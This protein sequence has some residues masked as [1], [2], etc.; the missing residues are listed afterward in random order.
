[1]TRVDVQD[2]GVGLSEQDQEVVFDRLWRADSA[3]ESNNGGL[4]IGLA[5]VR[6]IMDCMGGRAS[7]KSRLGE[8]STFT[9]YFPLSDL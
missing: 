8:G 7:V 5:M 3:R 4:G 6:E 2:S 9:L 1:M